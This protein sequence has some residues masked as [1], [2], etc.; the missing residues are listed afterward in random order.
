MPK[1]ETIAVREGGRAILNRLAKLLKEPICDFVPRLAQ[2]EAR[3]VE[4]RRAE[5]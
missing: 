2:R 4:K 3:R 1:Y 5:G